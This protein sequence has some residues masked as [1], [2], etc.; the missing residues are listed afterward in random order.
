MENKDTIILLVDDE[1]D[2]LEFL[3]YN[4]A[5]EGFQILK[6]RNGQKALEL[7]SEHKPHLILLDIMMPGLDGIETCNQLRRI[8][9][10]QHSLIVFLTARGEDYSQI[11]GF[12]AGAD[13][14]I[15]KPIKPKVLISRIQ[16][17]LRRLRSIPEISGKIITKEF[18]ID[19]D[20]YMVMKNDEE[21]ILA[22][23]EFEILQLLVSR[24]NKVFT[25]EDIF[26]HIWGEKV[27]VG[28]RTIDVHIRR[29]REKVGTDNIR[30]IKGVGYKYEEE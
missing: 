9:G 16:A 13:D 20:S 19:L 8:P 23:K 7:A 28:D 4:L 12:E 26:T 24:P 30:T 3:G 5:K 17:L 15:T 10:M 6:A 18:M 11:A 27:I 25:R 22:R 2:I 29:I 21:I 1:A 14:Y